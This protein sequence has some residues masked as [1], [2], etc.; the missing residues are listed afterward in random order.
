MPLGRPPQP[1]AAS[2][3]AAHTANRGARDMAQAPGVTRAHNHSSG[4]T[5]VKSPP[6][7]RPAPPDRSRPFRLARR[8]QRLGADDLVEVDP[9]DAL[10]RFRLWVGDGR[11]A[12]DCFGLT[13]HEQVAVT[14]F[15]TGAVGDVEPERLERPPAGERS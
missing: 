6:T 9:G 14:D 12:D 11:Y 15:V 10:D 7:L 1:A 8:V 4:R 5:R 3:R 13:H 2:D